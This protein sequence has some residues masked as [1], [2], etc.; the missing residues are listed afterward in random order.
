MR[1]VSKPR[2]ARGQ[3]CYHV[4]NFEH[5][6]EPPRVAD[7]GDLCTQCHEEAA[8]ETKRKRQKPSAANAL[9]RLKQDFI[10]QHYRGEGTCW[11]YIGEMREEWGITAE[12]RLPTGNPV[13]V[14]WEGDSL[15]YKG[16]AYYPANPAEMEEV[17]INRWE[18]QL[19]RITAQVVPERYLG[20]S[21]WREF[22]S[23]LV[24]YEP[25]DEGLPDLVKIGGAAP[26]DALPVYRMPD[27]W[28]LAGAYREFQNRAVRELYKLYSTELQKVEAKLRAR[29]LNT[30]EL[31]VLGLPDIRELF[32]EA[33][34]SSGVTDELAEELAQI[35]LN[36]YIR[37]DPQTNEVD[38]KRAHRAIRA[39]QERSSDGAPP[40]NPLVAIKCA[41]LRDDYGWDWRSIGE[42]CSLLNYEGKPSEDSVEEHIKDGLKLRKSK[43]R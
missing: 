6:E 31:E 4:R 14:P 36:Y 7:E 22:F 21:R 40:R 30:A 26:E 18:T 20:A 42:E 32:R 38:I 9:P 17:E 2:C 33:V 13:T 39:A 16:P 1:S 37:D 23:A 19:D 28:A 27:P 43:R 35:P 41:A 10:L 5:V 29:G 11:E 15:P 8:T 34:H 3:N 12:E 25:P 24:L